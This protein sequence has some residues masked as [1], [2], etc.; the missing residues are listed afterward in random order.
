MLKST[1]N[2]VKSFDQ[3]AFHWKAVFFTEALERPLLDGCGLFLR[4]QAIALAFRAGL[5]SQ[6]HHTE[7][8]GRVTISSTAMASFTVKGSAY[9]TPIKC[10]K[11]LHCVVMRSI[12]RPQAG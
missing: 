2:S 8:T 7:T 10:P 11:Y 9:S 3:L 5:H 6:P 4:L 1:P 12:S